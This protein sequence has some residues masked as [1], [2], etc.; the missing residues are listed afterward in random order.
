MTDFELIVDSCEQPRERPGDYQ[1]Q[2]KYYSGKKKNHTLKNQLIVLPNGEDIV[3]IAAGAPGPKSDI[4]FFRERQQ[5]FDSSQRFNGDKG[6]IGE[7]NIKT[8]QKKTKKQ[9]LTT[10]QKQQNKELSSERIFVEH[11]I[12][13]VKIFRVASERFRL[14][15]EKYEQII[16]TICGLVR[17]RI[18]ALILPF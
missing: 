18:G 17:L 6:Y 2:K 14:N 1:E 9:E 12:R 8:P 3:D 13:L 10:E 5:E 15:Q 11:I 4:N 7:P 16:L